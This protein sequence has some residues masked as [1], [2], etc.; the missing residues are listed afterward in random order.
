VTLSSGERKTIEG[1]ISAEE[2][3]IQQ[4]QERLAKGVGPLGRIEIEQD[5]QGSEGLIRGWIN[6]LRI[7]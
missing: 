5:I 7:G 3:H 2:H 4:K 1:Q 6:Q